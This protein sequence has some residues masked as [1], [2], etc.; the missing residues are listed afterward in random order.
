MCYSTLLHSRKVLRNVLDQVGPRYLIAMLTIWMVL[1]HMS[2]GR[3][4]PTRIRLNH[5]VRPLRPIYLWQSLTPSLNIFPAQQHAASNSLPPVVLPSSANPHQRFHMMSRL[6]ALLRLL[7]PRVS[8]NL[9]ASF[10]TL[11][12]EKYII[13]LE[14]WNKPLVP[15]GCSEAVVLSKGN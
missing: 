3:P 15:D 6:V 13:N 7:R 2:S 4:R 1:M 10:A 14:S 5:L 8:S 12:R 11:N 9:H